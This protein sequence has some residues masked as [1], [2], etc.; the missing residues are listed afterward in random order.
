[1]LPHLLHP[2][3]STACQAKLNDLQACSPHAHLTLTPADTPSPAI[4]WQAQPIN[5][6]RL[7]DALDGLFPDVEAYKACKLALS[8]RTQTAM[9]L[10]KHVLK[11][12]ALSKEQ[13]GALERWMG[14]NDLVDVNFLSRGMTA[15]AAV[16]ADM[17]VTSKLRMIGCGR[18]A[19]SC[20][21]AMYMCAGQQSSC[22]RHSICHMSV[23]DSGSL[24]VERELPVVKT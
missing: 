17:L 7:T 15:A 16:S 8:S 24:T 13:A 11:D 14:A 1:M 6:L 19:K 10:P 22:F 2:A 18:S 21:T 9:Q 3:T 12:A 5:Y 23:G 20:R 4:A